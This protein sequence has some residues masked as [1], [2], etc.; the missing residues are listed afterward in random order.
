[1][2]LDITVRRAR[3]L[4]YGEPFGGVRRH[5]TPIDMVFLY[6]EG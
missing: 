5:V 1:M 3:P 2:A 6:G 4:H